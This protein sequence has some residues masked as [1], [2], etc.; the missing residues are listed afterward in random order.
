MLMKGRNFSYAYASIRNFSVRLELKCVVRFFV[1]AAAE[2]HHSKNERVTSK[3]VCV[4][5][6]V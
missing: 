5:E 4:C 3:S 1:L 2:C 6:C